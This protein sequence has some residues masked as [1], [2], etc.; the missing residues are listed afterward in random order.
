MKSYK[1]RLNRLYCESKNIDHD[2]IIKLNNMADEENGYYKDIHNDF[3]EF[4]DWAT[5]FM[6]RWGIGKY[7]SKNKWG[8]RRYSQINKLLHNFMFTDKKVT[9]KDVNDKP[10]LTKDDIGDDAVFVKPPR[11]HHDLKDEIEQKIG[12]TDFTPNDFSMVARTETARMKAVYQ[13]LGFKKQGLKYVIY[14]TKNDNRVGEDHKKLNNK[15]YEID[16]LLGSEGEKVRIP[17]RPNC[18]CRYQAS[19]RGL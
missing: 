17:N 7:I 14:K 8:N 12:T 3:S 5:S 2:E 9:R 4:N 11:N 1:E 6:K 16:W 10:D 18:R 15:E 13:L 19:M